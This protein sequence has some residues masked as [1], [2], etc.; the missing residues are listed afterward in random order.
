[1]TERDVLA[2]DQRDR[3]KMI[4]RLQALVERVTYR[5]G[6]EFY[7]GVTKGMKYPFLQ[8][9]HWRPDA[10]DPSCMGWGHG[11]KAY[12]TQ[13]ATDSE[14]IQTML[15]LAK[16]YEEHEVREFFLVDGKRPYGP[17]IDVNALIGVAEELD[18]RSAPHGGG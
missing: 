13:W 1:M 17:H 14:I 7:I 4:R 11:G 18:V 3:D 15:G 5:E 8:I 6:Y 10:F 9:R 16:S 2:A 12:I